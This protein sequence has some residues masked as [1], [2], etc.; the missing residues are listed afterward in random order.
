MSR[1]RPEVSPATPQLRS[2][3]DGRLLAALHA[4]GTVRL[5]CTM[6]SL[7][8]AFDLGEWLMILCDE[9]I[10]KQALHNVWGRR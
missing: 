9:E 8:E 1:R 3:D 5:Y 10:E 4:D 7:A 2:Q 6:F